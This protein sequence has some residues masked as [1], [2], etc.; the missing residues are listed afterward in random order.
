MPRHKQISPPTETNSLNVLLF[1]SGLLSQIREAGPVRVAQGPR[2]RKVEDQGALR[3]VERDLIPVDRVRMYVEAGWARARGQRR[4]GSAPAHS[5]QSS[6]PLHMMCLC[7]LHY[8]STAGT[9]YTVSRVLG[10][11]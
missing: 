8:L 11:S 5:R 3:Q 2:R 9:F 6:A 10:S 4:H 1:F 7:Q